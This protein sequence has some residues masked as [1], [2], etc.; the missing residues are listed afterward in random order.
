MLY[1]ALLLVYG[2]MLHHR[3]DTKATTLV[4]QS[5]IAHTSPQT[6]EQTD[7]FR[8]TLHHRSHCLFI[9]QFGYLVVFFNLRELRQI[10]RLGNT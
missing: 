7:I 3:L 5:E 4:W 1:S 10:R 6:A 2:F 9:L 8:A